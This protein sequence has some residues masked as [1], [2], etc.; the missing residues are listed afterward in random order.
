[1]ASINRHGVQGTY[2]EA[3]Q[4][5]LDNEFGTHVDEE[6]IKQILEKGTVQ[7]SKVSPPSLWFSKVNRYPITN[8]CSLDART[9]GNQE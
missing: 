7:E 2:D 4:S 9:P 1:M 6:V 8:V 3:S 5:V